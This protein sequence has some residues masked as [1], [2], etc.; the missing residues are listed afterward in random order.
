MKHDTGFIDVSI[1][2]Q[3][4]KL[5]L[6]LERIEDIGEFTLFCLHAFGDGLNLNELSQVTEID[7]MTIQKHLDF[8]VKRGFVNEK[9]KISA[10][11]RNILKLHDEI[12]KFNRTNRVVFLE[13]AVRE[14][15]KRWRE[16]QELT[17]R[18]YGWLI[19]GEDLSLQE[20]EKLYNVRKDIDQVLHLLDNAKGFKDV[21][22]EIRVHLEP[23]GVERFLVFKINPKALTPT[24]IEGKTYARAIHGEQECFIEIETLCKQL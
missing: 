6:C 1:P 3:G 5:S 22:D 11:G 18:S 9:H 10:Y 23:K 12:N 15:V 13:N 24:K 16:R 8:L 2:Y 19:A 7:S 4:Y 17:D 14:K 21:S 20:F